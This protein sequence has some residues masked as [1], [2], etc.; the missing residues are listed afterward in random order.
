MQSLSQPHVAERPP[1]RGNANIPN[2][3][4]CI[5]GR[6]ESL[7][8]E[9]VRN[10]EL[11][12]GPHIRRFERAIADYTGAAHAVALANGTAALHLALLA[13]GARPDDLVLMPTLTF[14]ATANA[15][16]YCGADPVF[17]DV[18]P[19]SWSIDV[20]LLEQ[21]LEKDCE[22]R[23]RELFLR[24]NGRR[25]AAIL[26]VDLYGH[27]ADVDPILELAQRF[28]LAVVQDGAEALGARYKGRKLGSYAP[29]CCLSFNGNKIIT[30]GNGGMVVTSDESIAARI[31]YLS[32][33]AKDDPIEFIHGA[34]GFNYRM[35]NINAALALAQSENLDRFVARK[36]A[37]VERYASWFAKLDGI[38]MWREAPWAKSSHWMAMLTVDEKRYPGAVG[39]LR[40][41][42]PSRGI[43]ARPAWLPLHRQK[44]FA[45]S[46][47]T[48]IEVA[49]RIY[50][51]SLCL[52]CSVGLTEQ[53]LDFCAQTIITYFANYKGE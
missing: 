23:N 48:G 46:M 5:E 24:S 6:E 35:P 52:P 29:V 3:I 2:C 19:V 30:G 51:T 45:G 9:A 43:E 32:T 8:A 42:L 41:Y 53:E 33:Q 44:P 1:T 14:A 50:R 28:S 15:V 36:R 49:E 18:D 7:V 17:F 10:G 13:V 25:V 11:A 40:K 39:H 26:P 16:K 31:R 27:P 12:V 4:P 38:A 20:T 47:N 34:I 37:F 22:P 21:F